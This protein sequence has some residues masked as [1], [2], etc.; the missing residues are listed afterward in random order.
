MSRDDVTLYCGDCGQPFLFTVGEQQFYA[1]RNIINLPTRCPEC[2]AKH[3][4][5]VDQ[6]L[7][8]VDCNQSFVFSK[9]E[10][11]FFESRSMT[12]PTRCPA[13]RQQ[14]KAQ[15]RGNSGS[16]PYGQRQMYSVFCSNC[17]MQTQVPFQP[18]PG[19]AIYCRSC[20]PA[21]RKSS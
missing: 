14:H 19:R 12:A 7:I 16:N 10:Q 11:A 3:K 9:G 5:R 4:A 15:P 6:N 21:H 13:C 1:S 20:Y 2:R 17:G 18:T 8:C